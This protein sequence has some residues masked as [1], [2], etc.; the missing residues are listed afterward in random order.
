MQQLLTWALLT[1]RQYSMPWSEPP[2]MVMGAVPASVR[3]IF[4]PIRSRGSWMRR[5]GR[6]FSDSS[7]ESVTV[8]GDPAQS[9]ASRRMPVPELPTSSGPAGSSILPPVPWMERMPFSSNQER[10]P[11]ASMALSVFRQSSAWRKPE[12]VLTPDDMPA[13]RAVRCEMLLS[14]GTRTLPPVKPPGCT[15]L[16]W[17]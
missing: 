3:S 13:R 12:M 16:L 5:I 6:E 8:M 11:K 2:W 9:P 17:V 4:A 7:P 14:P 10:A 1:G 15:I